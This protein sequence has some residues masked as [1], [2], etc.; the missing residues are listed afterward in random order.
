MALFLFTKA[1]M[2]GR[3]IDVFNH[4]K[5]VR[6]FTFID[7]IVEGVVRVIDRPATPNPG[8]VSVD[9]DPATSNVPYCVFNIGN[10]QPVPLM[11]YIEALERALGITAVKNFLPMQA[12]DVPATFANTDE[13]S[14]WI[15]FKPDTPVGVGV[16]RFVDWYR[17]YYHSGPGRV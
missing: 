10:S 4:G 3:A 11:T 13:L 9:P 12:G 5:M 15:G 7:D 8:W 17:A 16:Q 6:D 14:Q 1:I 2:E